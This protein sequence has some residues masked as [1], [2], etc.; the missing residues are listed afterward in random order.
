MPT[1]KGYTDKGN[2]QNYLLTLIDNSFNN[3][4]D[5]WICSVEDY[6][7]QQT[8]RNFIAA[9]VATVKLYDGDGSNEILIDDCVSVTDLEILTTEGEVVLD[10]LVQGEDYFLEPA[11]D[12]PKQS[13]RLYGYKFT[14]GIQNIKVTAKWG[15]STAVPA[16]IKFAATVLVSNIINF[17]NQ[18]E[19]EI[20]NMS[21][22][23]YSVSFKDQAKRDDFDRVQEI[24]NNYV[25]Y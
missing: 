22:G 16:D 7:D 25:R 9:T 3:Q 6:I 10:T 11:N 8:G 18:S 20:N 21:I 12:T 14:K 17:S 4:V 2:I 24:L 13:I 5:D 1:P 19:G 15:Y 23:S